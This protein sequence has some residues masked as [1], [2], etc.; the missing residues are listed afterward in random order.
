MSYEVQA[1]SDPDVQAIEDY[2]KRRAT[3]ALLDLMQ[4]NLSTYRSG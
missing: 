2:R 1:P 3:V 4:T